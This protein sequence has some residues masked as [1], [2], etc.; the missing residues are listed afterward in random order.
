[1]DNNKTEREKMTGGEYCGIASKS[2]PVMFAHFVTRECIAIV[3][4]KFFGRL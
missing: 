4:D 2:D 3:K 1:M